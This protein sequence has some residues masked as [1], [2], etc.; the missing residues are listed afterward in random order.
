MKRLTVDFFLCICVFKPINSF[1]TSYEACLPPNTKAETFSITTTTGLTKENSVRSVLP[2]PIS[3]A[4][5]V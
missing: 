5:S 3:R 1:Y 2:T 4:D